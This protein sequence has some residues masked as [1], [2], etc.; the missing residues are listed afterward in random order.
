MTTHEPNETQPGAEQ[1]SEAYRAAGLNEAPPAELDR[2]ILAKAARSNRRPLAS[3]LPPLALAATVLLSVSI[4][5]RTGV[6]NQDAEIFSDAPAEVDD[7][8]DALEPG[9]AGFREVAPE[10]AA[11][12][13]ALNSAVEE[14]I[15]VQPQSL[16]AEETPGADT[17]E[18]LLENAEIRAR[19][20]TPGARQEAAGANLSV[21][22]TAAEATVTLEGITATPGLGCTGADTNSEPPENWLACIADGLEQGQLNGARNE[23]EAF[24]TVYPG[25]TLPD[26]LESL[27]SP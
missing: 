4:V 16:E 22:S 7:A 5:L 23:L 21:Q 17:A 26:E 1:V 14:L 13:D 12:S 24:L 18:S 27:A 25:Y 10:S 6:L 8:L 3:L 15:D 11:S 2:A 19:R 9:R 20:A